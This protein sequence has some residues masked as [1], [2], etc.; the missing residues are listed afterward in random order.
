MHGRIRSFLV[1]TCFAAA[2]PGCRAGATGT[3]AYVGATVFDGTG[4]PVTR[5]A[6]LLVSDGRIEA[7]GPRADVRVPRGTE[8][9]DVTG[10]WIIPGLIDA[11]VHAE[12][13]TLRPYLSYGVTSVR[14]M[15]GLQDSVIF[16]R[17][18]VASGTMDGPRL[19]IS[20]AMIDGAP[21]TWNGATAVR[22]ATDARRAVGNRVLIDAA[23]IK[24]YTKIDRRLLEPVLDEAKALATPV[25][26]HLGK[27][28]ALTAARL[29]VRSLEHMS[30]VVTSALGN[31]APIIAAHTE[32]FPG[33]NL[34]ERSW[35]RPD[36]AA[37]DRTARA[38]AQAG[39]AIVPTLVLHEAWGH[40]D[41]PAYETSL[42]LTGV[43]A[44]VRR[45]WN[46]PNLIVRAGLRPADFAAF[47]QSRPNQD[48]FVRLF[49]RAGG[50][51][52]AGSDSPN[53]LIPPGASLHRE[54]RLLVAAD[55]TTEQAL[56]AAT[57][58]AARLLGADSIGVLRPGAVA[59]F[60]VLTRD[61]LQDIA[62]L[63][64]IEAVVAAGYRY[65]PADLRRA[66]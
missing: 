14:D 63:S 1:L 56:L 45:G 47:R 35:A 66:P 51:V 36:S 7:V 55:L 10:R 31:P 62:N 9:V 11:H 48:L 46:V 44:A 32:F 40:L 4:T 13:W 2:L 53:Q 6:V 28:D 25:A 37:L 41:D 20:G 34:E 38:L 64:A 22:T 24:I 18:D 23:Q 42:D 17:D 29:G 33:W 26:A 3:T 12:R 8:T 60:L 59:D 61:P 16:L 49:R 52:A 21:P 43:P 50:L 57:R 54:L 15:G 58:D 65:D 39:V 30:G 27:V 5:D 19:Y